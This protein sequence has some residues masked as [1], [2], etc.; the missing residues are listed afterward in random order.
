M[1]RRRI[2]IHGLQQQARTNADFQRAAD[3][4]ANQQLEQVTV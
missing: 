1:A 4:L 2:G 3:A